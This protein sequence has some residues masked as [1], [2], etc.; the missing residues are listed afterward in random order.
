MKTVLN[1]AAF[2]TGWFA[3]ALGAASGF[4]LA[5]PSIVAMLLAVHFFFLSSKPGREMVL[6]VSTGLIGT[7]IDSLLMS[8]GLYTFPSHPSSGVCPLWMTT[9]WMIFASTF[10][11]ALSWLRKRYLLAIVFGSIG[12]PLSY[13]A[14]GRLGALTLSD[15]AT[16]SLVVL[17]IVWGAVMPTLLRLADLLLN[18]PRSSAAAVSGLAAWFFLVLPVAHASQFVTIE[19]VAFAKQYQTSTLSLPLRGYGLLRYRIFF[20]AY[21]AALYLGE[22]IPASAV[23]SDV[24]KRLEIEY[25]WSIKGKDFGPAGEDILKQN[26][27]TQTV[28]S[29]RPRIEQINAL[30]QDVKPGDRYS[31]TYIPGTGTELAFNNTPK[32]VVKGADFAAAYFSIW[33]GA[34]PLDDSLKTKL[35]SN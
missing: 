22:D 15:E 17:A 6:I 32:G 2:Y 29:L 12:G 26:V 1:F 16:M 10:D 33:L 5:G 24:P 27:S 23:L 13:L 28:A 19:D 21:V 3:C 4:P 7:G 14:G 31:L 30:Y 25:F 8:H 18:A 34:K 35:L 9:L 11:H 20:K